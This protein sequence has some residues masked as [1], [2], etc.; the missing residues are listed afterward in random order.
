MHTRVEVRRGGAIV[1]YNV[2]FAALVEDALR[3]DS[4]EGGELEQIRDSLENLREAM[5]KLL[6][7]LVYTHKLTLDDAAQIAGIY[8]ELHELHD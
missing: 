6:D 3:A 8:H 7:Q 1:D 5:A 4:Y 2:S